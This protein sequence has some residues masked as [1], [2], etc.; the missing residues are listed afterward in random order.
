MMNRSSIPF[1][2]GL[3]LTAIGTVLLIDNISNTSIWRRAVI[4]W[5]I[6]LLIMAGWSLIRGIAVL[7]KNQKIPIS[8]WLGEAVFAILIIVVGLTA[9]AMANW[10]S[11]PLLSQVPLVSITRTTFNRTPAFKPGDKLIVTAPEAEIIVKGAGDKQA[12]IRVIGAGAG[13]DKQTAISSINRLKVSLKRASGNLTL[14]VKRGNNSHLFNFDIPG[15]KIIISLPRRADV[16]LTNRYGNI[17]ATGLSGNLKIKTYHGD[18]NLKRIKGN[19]SVISRQGDFTAVDIGGELAVA[20]RAGDIN[21]FNWH[22]LNK[23]A[24]IKTRFGDISLKIPKKSALTINA[25]SKQGSIRQNLSTRSL[26]IVDGN[27]YSTS[28][29]GGGPP[30]YVAT[31]SGA[32]DLRVF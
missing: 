12:H 14:S 23:P 8:V 11:S 15:S 13:I 32:I 27:S 30:V 5:P 2:F 29:N 17:I 22:S 16:S 4:Y 26:K 6:I 20:G 10:R 3:L 25:A 24:K 21:I 9:T 7:I 19:I 1:I 31:Q 28:L 18:V